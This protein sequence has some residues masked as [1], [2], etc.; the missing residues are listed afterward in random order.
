VPPQRPASGRLGLVSDL[1]DRWRAAAGDAGAT[2]GPS[3]V[4]AGVDLLARWREAHRHYHTVEHL[5]AV[6]DVVDAYAHVAARPELVRLAAWFHDAVYDPWTSADGNERASAALAGVVLGQVG[7]PPDAIGEVRRL[8]LLT[9]G[10]DVAPGD[11]DGALLCDADLAILASPAPDYDRYAAAVRREYGHLPDDEFRAGR[12]AVL[13]HLLAL[14]ALFRTPPLAD[15]WERAARANL[16][17]ELAALRRG[18]APG[19][20][21]PDPRRDQA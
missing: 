10:H 4:P 11:P 16:A 3:V 19:S 9:A 6:L 7:V 21:E 20:A 14:P 18:A 12:T 2:S 15:R 8:V 13:D 1:I 17:R 5:V